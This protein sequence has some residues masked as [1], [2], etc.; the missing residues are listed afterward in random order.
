MISDVRSQLPGPFILLPATGSHLTRLSETDVSSL[1][2]PF[3][4][5][6]YSYVNGNFNLPIANCQDFGYKYTLTTIK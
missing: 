4:A 6:V 3:K 5:F 1:L 2:F